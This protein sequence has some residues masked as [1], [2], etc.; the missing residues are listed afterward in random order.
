MWV[1][2]YANMYIY[3]YTHLNICVLHTYIHTYIHTCMHACMHACVLTFT[4]RMYFD[5]D[6][7]IHIEINR[8]TY[9]DVTLK[10]QGPL[11]SPKPLHQGCARGPRSPRQIC[12]PF[13]VPKGG[14]GLG[15]RVLG[16][17]VSHGKYLGLSRGSYLVAVG[18]SIY[19]VGTWTLGGVPA[20]QVSMP[21]NSLL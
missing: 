4:K 16:F 18:P 1:S 10:P 14:Q 9:T 2:N 19:Y 7:N 21:C 13:N 3:I 20:I 11:W 15:F 5:I 8:Y 17:R 6:R 12:W